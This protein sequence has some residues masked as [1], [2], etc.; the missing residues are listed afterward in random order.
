MFKIC[1]LLLSSILLIPVIGNAQQNTQSSSGSANLFNLKKMVPTSPEAAMLGR[2][3]DIPIGYYTGTADISIPLYTINE[4]GLSI[5]IVLR[6]HS[7]GVKVEDQASNVG[8][9][10][11]LEPGGAIIKVIN[12]RDDASELN[13][14]SAE[15][16]RG[17][18]YLMNGSIQGYYTTRPDAGR[19]LYTCAPAGDLQ[20]SPVTIGGLKDGDGQPDIYQYSFPGGYSGKFY[21]NP[22]TNIPVLLDKKADFKIS[23]LA[24]NGGFNVTTLKGDVYTFSE[25]ES[26]DVFGTYST[27]TFKLSN[28]RLYNGKEINFSYSPGQY[29]WY[30]YNETLHSSYGFAMAPDEDTRIFPHYTETTHK[31]KNLTAII[32]KEVTV[33][34]NLED[35][36]DML[37]TNDIDDIADNGTLSIKRIKSIDIINTTSNQKIKTF[38]FNYDYF[39]YSQI[40]GSYWNVT[41]PTQSFMDAIGK[42]LKLLSLQEIGYLTNGQPISNNPYQFT[43]NESITLPLKTSFARDFWGYYNGINN[44]KMIPDLSYFFYSGY[45]EYEDMPSYMLDY[46]KGANRTTDVSKLT[47]GIL[48]QITYPTKGYT[49]FEYE[50]HTFSNYS[51]PDVNQISS[52][53]HDIALVDKNAPAVST[54]S[55]TFSFSRTQSIRF[56][57]QI[58]RGPNQSLTFYSLQPST[59]V[60]SKLKDG[61]SSTMKTW[62]MTGSDK[63]EFDANGVITWTDDITFPY[64]SGASYIITTELPDNLGVQNDYMNQ[65]SAASYFTYYSDPV[66]NYKVSYGAGVR[67]KAVENYSANNVLTERKEISYLNDDNSTSGLLMAPINYMYSND[68]YFV[69]L[70]SNDPSPMSRPSWLEG[71]YRVWFLSSESA[72]PFSDAASGSPVGYSKV[73]EKVISPNGDTNGKHVYI[74]NNI[75]SDIHKNVPDNPNLLNGSIQTEEIYNNN[76]VK[77]LATSFSYLD[78]QTIYYNGI[79]IFSNVYGAMPCDWYPRNGWN[80]AQYPH[81]GKDT[82][83]FYPLNSHW[84]MLSNKT[85][86]QYFNGVPVQQQISYT[87][88]SKGQIIQETNLNSKGQSLVTTYKFPIDIPEAERNSIQ[89]ALVDSNFLDQLLEQHTYNNQIEASQTKVSYDIINDQL[90]KSTIENSVG[91]KPLYNEVTFTSYGPN[92]TLLQLL[93]KGVAPVSFIWANERKSVSAQVNNA[94]QSDIAYSSFENNKDKGNWIYDETHI[95]NSMPAY[96]GVK[97]YDLSSSTIIKSGLITS[98]TYIVSYWS[99]NGSCSGLGSTSKQG[100]TV[101]GWTYFEHQ[102]TGQATLAITGNSLIDDLRLYPKEAQMTTYTYAPLIGMT[103]S[104][105][106]KGQTTY[107]EYDSFQRLLNIKDQNGKVLKHYEYHYK[108]Q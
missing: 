19:D 97:S 56:R 7:S 89:T 18:S 50:P 11:S 16:P 85:S 32:T 84:Y 63:P 64:E 57:T 24:N 38:N 100:I 62:Q 40:G 73:V 92:K 42:R 94:I 9:G 71:R 91:G 86:V 82:I 60:L 108:D 29:Q 22:Q 79:K 88:N 41:S 30:Y 74:Y 76:D 43:Y 47:A 6:Y 83:K 28:I 93:N 96:T 80:F 48:T 65:A 99:R 98:K 51:Y 105:D 3:G 90:V 39:S 66:G 77:L 1:I 37:G 44:S 101:N 107:Y 45:K 14:L 46:V 61:V 87:Y 106:A 35:R 81:I 4:G 26:A 72:V 75:Q 67:V 49:Q 15:D 5:P 53:K 95:S 17:F 104:T 68:M 54:K 78:L 23:V 20:D 8:L 102:I 33:K 55:Y 21:I 36:I 59:I 27:Y 13:K 34:F 103:S 58:S 25:V 31:T 69:K 2:F 10:W 70:L 52:T 12:G